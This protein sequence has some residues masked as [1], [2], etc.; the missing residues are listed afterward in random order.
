MDRLASIITALT[1]LVALVAAL[2]AEW[3]KLSGIHGLVKEQ[4]ETM[5]SKVD[6]LTAEMAK[7]EA[8]IPP[9]K[10]S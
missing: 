5:V 7:Q 4:H 6:E 10:G 8:N 1:A 9:S 2:V 3:R